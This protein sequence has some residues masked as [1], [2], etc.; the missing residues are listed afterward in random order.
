MPTGARKYNKALGIKIKKARNELGWT[1]N[2]LSDKTGVSR[3]YL[4]QIENEGY[5]PSDRVI[6]L[7]YE[8]IDTGKK[9]E[10]DR[11][12][13]TLGDNMKEYRM[14]L[15]LSFDRLAKLTG[16]SSGR[17]C[18]IENNKSYPGIDTIKTIAKAL[19][20][21]VEDLKKDTKI[22]D[23]KRETINLAVKESEFTLITKY[24]GLNTSN[25]NQVSK[26][27]NELYKKAR[28]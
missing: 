18:F 14:K 1:V 11:L 17:L 19:N 3:A 8:A 28:K 2:I 20:V 26:L 27:I 23:L 21:T 9:V 22:K 16:I 25:K 6:S 13:R 15:N 4:Y 24:R 7:I 5:L 12:D 10:L